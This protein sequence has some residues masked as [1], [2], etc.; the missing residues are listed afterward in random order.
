M[1]I[2]PGPDDAVGMV[3][4]YSSP[5]TLNPR[6]SPRAHGFLVVGKP[7]TGKATLAAK[8][9]DKLGVVHVGFAQVCALPPLPPQSQL[10]PRSSS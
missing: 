2:V 6:P 3:W 4:A 5:T 1:H 8:M 10:L 9:A 7:G